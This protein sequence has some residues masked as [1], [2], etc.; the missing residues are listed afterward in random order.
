[1]FRFAAGAFLRDLTVPARAE[2]LLKLAAA[3]SASS[4]TDRRVHAADLA[5]RASMRNGLLAA[6]ACVTR[7]VQRLSPQ[8][9]SRE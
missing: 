8:V 3:A 4:P 1:M 6:N 7:A 2:R 5:Q 9:A